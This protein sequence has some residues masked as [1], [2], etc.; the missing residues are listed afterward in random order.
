[1]NNKA[2][3]DIGAWWVEL[4][5]FVVLV[6]GFVFSIMLQSAF[7]SYVVILL[8]GLLAGRFLYYRRHG[9]PFYL[10]GMALLLGYVLGTR[11]GDWK[12][13]ILFFLL[14]AAASY[15]MHAEGYLE[16]L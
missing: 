10:I 13:V 14:G 11:Y 7:T 12:L 16:N 9:F 1:M 4:A 5:C 3:I 8:F 15:Y 6:I 2:L